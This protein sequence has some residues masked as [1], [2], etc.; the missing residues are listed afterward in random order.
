[1]GAALIWRQHLP[2]HSSKRSSRETLRNSL[3]SR[4]VCTPSV[5]DVLVGSHLRINLVKA[6]SYLPAMLSSMLTMKARL[7]R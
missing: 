5:A 4:W 6:L 1:M 2:L 3:R 7:I